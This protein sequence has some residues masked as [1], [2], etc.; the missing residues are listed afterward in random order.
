M[1]NTSRRLVD[2]ARDALAAER[3]ALI[4]RGRGSEPVELG[5]LAAIATVAVL[6]ELVFMMNQAEVAEI[7]DGGDWPSAHD[8]HV[9]A[10]DVEE[11]P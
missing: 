10:N 11:S 7:V 8:L 2:A 9:L 1:N 6:R 4:A 5:A 3:V